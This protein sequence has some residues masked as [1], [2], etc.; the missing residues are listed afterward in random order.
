[1]DQSDTA[2]NINKV[3]I[4]DSPVND[5]NI[6]YNYVSSDIEDDIEHSPSVKQPPLT[7]PMVAEMPPQP[8]TSEADELAKE[9]EYQ[10]ELQERLQNTTLE[11]QPPAAE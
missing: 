8:D 6:E 4:S 5:D 2:E 10:R 3:Y 9:A 1:M 11:D 7:E